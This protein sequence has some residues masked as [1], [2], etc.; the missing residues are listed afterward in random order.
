MGRYDGWDLGSPSSVHRAMARRG[1]LQPV[2]YQAERRQ[3]AAAR[4]EVFMDPPA[5]LNRVWQVDFSAFETTTEGTWQLCGV[6]DYAA[7]V[8]LACPVTAT[9]TATDLLGALEAAIDAAEALLEHPLI[10]DCVD[11]ATGD[12]VP[13]VV[14]TDNGPAMK[15]TAV[16]RWFAARPHLADCVAAFI[17]EY[18]TIRP[19]ET[20]AWRRPLDTYLTDPTLKP[21]PRKREQER[22][23][24]DR[25][26]QQPHQTRQT[27]RLRIPPLRPLPHPR[28]PLRRQTQLDPPRQ[29]HS[30]LKTEAPCYFRFGLLR[31]GRQQVGGC[32][33]FSDGRRVLSCRRPAYVWPLRSVRRR[34]LGSRYSGSPGGVCA[35]GGGAISSIVAVERHGG[36]RPLGGGRCLGRPPSRS[37]LARGA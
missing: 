31:S 22:M 1:L 14:V 9:Q 24:R 19:H 37:G 33:P 26:D 2:R 5:R 32:L 35:R 3:L 6:V 10:E 17:D 12:V 7:K 36:G 23:T 8:A 18:N 13:L 21:K 25:S 20:L 28:A 34:V 29:P 15:S 16:A 11:E 27:R 4:R 30:P